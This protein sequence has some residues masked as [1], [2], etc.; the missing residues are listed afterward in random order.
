MLSPRNARVAAALAARFPDVQVAD[1]NQAVLD[2]SDVVFLAVR[3]Q[4]ATEVM[5]GL[6]FRPEHRV[7]SL[8]ATY[9]RDRIAALVR[10]AQ[11][12]CCAV[13]MP[14]VSQHL[15]PTPIYPP[16]P[17][18]ASIFAGL[19]TAIEVTTEQELQALWASSALM[20]TYYMLLETV[21]AWLLRMGVPDSR[22]REHVAMMFEGL[23]RVPRLSPASFVD[24][25]QEFQTKGGLNAQCVAQLQAAGVFD[26]LGSALDGI[27]TRIQG[28]V[29]P[30]PADP[31]TPAADGEQ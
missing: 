26:A 15:G 3:P 23:G 27:L 5:A 29:G 18:V 12:V 11:E 30:L 28:T 8:I 1:S 31:G 7:V 22:A 20:A 6:Q 16:D 19:G 17:V 2:G 24:T 14:T 10:P 13:P 21:Q 9:S 25:A 4:V